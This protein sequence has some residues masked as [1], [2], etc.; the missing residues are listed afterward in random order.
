M[1]S[2]E[3]YPHRSGHD[4]LLL[5]QIEL[6]RIIAPSRSNNFTW[7]VKSWNVIHCKNLQE[8][9]LTSQR[10]NVLPC[11]HPYRAFLWKGQH[12]V[13]GGCNTTFSLCRWTFLLF[14]MSHWYLAIRGSQ[15]VAGV[16]REHW[17]F[18]LN[19]QQ[20]QLATAFQVNAQV[21]FLHKLQVR[22]VLVTWGW[23]DH[24]L[25]SL[26]FM[27]DPKADQCLVYITALSTK[28]NS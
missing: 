12:W 19:S 14:Q 2:W 18:S 23:T 3:N 26:G 21:G 28:N 8:V 9:H 1:R 22:N 13:E 15:T 6:C 10:T 16:R 27:P 4:R 7:F 20:S 25:K 11:F 24:F 5:L 17:S